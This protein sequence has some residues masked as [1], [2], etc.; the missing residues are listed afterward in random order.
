M[1][2]QFWNDFALP[3]APIAEDKRSV[4]GNPTL[5]LDDWIYRAGAFL[6]EPR[7]LTVLVIVVILVLPTISL[8]NAEVLFEHERSVPEK[9]IPLF[10]PWVF[11]IYFM[12]MPQ[13]YAA[14]LESFDHLCQSS[15]ANAAERA[16]IRKQ[17]VHPGNRFQLLLLLVSISNHSLLSE[18]TSGVISRFF[19][20]DWNVVDLWYFSSGALANLIFIWILMM[21]ISRMFLLTMFI[22]SSVRPRLFDIGIGHPLVSI[23]VCAGLV[24]A[25][26]TALQ[27]AIIVAIANGAELNWSWKYLFPEVAAGLLALVFIL[28]PASSL[29]RCIRRTKRAEI[30]IVDAAIN[31]KISECH[32]L[33]R[34]GELNS[35]VLQLLD[36]RERLIS[37][38]E[39]PLNARNARRFWFYFLIA[40][41]TW[42]ASAVVQVILERSALG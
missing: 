30:Q 21:P 5:V 6:P 29:A 39:W 33:I 31:A 2:F 15:T 3:K 4:T 22:R 35:D 14:I 23:G 24:L 40:P 36:Y 42:V 38:P 41:L 32:T 16:A 27:T 28:V 20:G 11:L 19:K 25:V 12:G 7:A 13:L 18:M 26:P 34:A 17:L 9:L 37:M 10:L 1:N 8:Y